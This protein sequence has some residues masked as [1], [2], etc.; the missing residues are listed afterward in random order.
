MEKFHAAGIDSVLLQTSEGLMEHEFA[1]IHTG[2]SCGGKPALAF[3]QRSTVAFTEQENI[4]RAGNLGKK[5]DAAALQFLSREDE[6]HP[7]VMGRERI[8]THD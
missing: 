2:N 5:S 7:A 8:K 6:L 3:E 1:G 4:F